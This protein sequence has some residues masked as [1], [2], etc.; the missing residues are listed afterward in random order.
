[1][2]EKGRVDI[3]RLVELRRKFHAIAELGF[4]EK[5]TAHEI[6]QILVDAGLDVKENIGGTGVLGVVNG[7]MPGKTLMVRAD[8]DGLPLNEATGLPFASTSGA[9]HACGHD[10]HIAIALH[11][12]EVLQARRE[13]LCGKVAFVFQPAEEI[14]GGAIA[15]IEDGVLND[16]KPDRV[17]GLHI[18]NGAPVGSAG[19]NSGSVFASAD[20]FRITVTGKGGHGAL[21]HLSV[22]PVVAAS[23]IVTASQTIVTRELPPNEMGL[24]TFGKF[25]SGFAPN[26]IPDTAILEGTIRAYKP[27]V[28]ST[29]LSSLQR[30]AN[31]VASALNAEAHFEHLYGTPPVVND[32]TV[33]RW[34]SRIAA[35]ILGEDA[36]STHD[37]VSVGDD[38]SE[39]LNRNTRLVPYIRRRK[40]RGGTPSQSPALTLTKAACPLA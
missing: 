21:P 30:I 16:V 13:D 5:R 12:A 15:M 37:P 9:M 32:P 18:W 27:E 31:G 24:V 34:V 3:P 38:M 2:I 6:A 35:G 20:A 10:G 7:A 19:V 11:T 28:R 14:I 1:M 25:E 40:R 39:F 17:I 29:L 36:V 4:K 8:I 33:A 22:D 23:H 26:V